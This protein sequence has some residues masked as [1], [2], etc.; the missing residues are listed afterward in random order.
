MR[1]G[2]PHSC[3]LTRLIGRIKSGRSPAPVVAALMTC[4]PPTGG[5]CGLPGGGEA[6]LCGVVG[7]IRARATQAAG[8]GL[9]RADV[10]RKICATVAVVVAV[11]DDVV[12]VGADG[13]HVLLD[14]EG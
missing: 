4:L 12:E 1:S 11:R 5:P 9:H 14:G 6:E 2:L 3:R 13:V 7:S 10:L 8:V